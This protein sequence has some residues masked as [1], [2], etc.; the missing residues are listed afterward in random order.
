M[1]NNVPGQET[2]EAARA[3][4]SRAPESSV[5]EIQLLPNALGGLLLQN[6][7]LGLPGAP[8]EALL[9]SGAQVCHKSRQ[10]A[11]E[12]PRATLRDSEECFEWDYSHS[13]PL[14][15]RQLMSPLATQ[16][17]ISETKSPSEE[18]VFFSQV[19]LPPRWSAGKSAFRVFTLSWCQEQLIL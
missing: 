16:A 11:V 14:C 5:E 12:W 9:S 2:L 6:Q 15:W 13:A 18:N 8:R 4:S 19:K 3:G 1:S 10:R 7:P 17:F